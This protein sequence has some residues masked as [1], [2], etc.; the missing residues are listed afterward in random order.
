MH[1][2][3]GIELHFCEEGEGFF[4]SR[5]WEEAMAPGRVTLLFAPQVHRVSADPKKE[6]CRTVLHIPDD[7]IQKCLDFLDLEDT[8]FLPTR[9]YPVLQ[10]QPSAS[11]SMDIRRVLRQ[12][13]RGIRSGEAE[14]EITP[15]ITLCL[16][17]LLHQ[18]SH[19]SRSNRV[20]YT[21]HSPHEQYLMERAC[22]IIDERPYDLTAA[23]LTELL[24]ISQG[25]LWRL[26][27]GLLGKSPKEYLMERRMEAAK[28]YLLS[29]MSVSAVA[30]TCRYSDVSSFSRAFKNHVGLSPRAYVRSKA[31][32]GLHK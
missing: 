21:S 2:H 4:R 26:F 20:A 25:H 13:G 18:L 23:M 10:Q 16:A 12:L 22:R 7:V 1:A 32:G 3:L 24:G 11:E 31:R 9:D 29:G 27:D 28:D 17:E 19:T 5:K 15:P 6:Y 30:A 14:H 8:S